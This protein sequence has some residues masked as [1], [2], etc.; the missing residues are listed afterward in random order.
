MPTEPVARNTHQWSGDEEI[1]YQ[2]LNAMAHGWLG[3]DTLAADTSALTSQTTIVKVNT[4][5]YEDNRLIK[6]SAYGTFIGATPDLVI[7]RL[8]VS[9]S[10][11]AN[12]HYTYV[13]VNLLSS[14]FSI[15]GR[16]VPGVAG[17]ASAYATIERAGSGSVI[18]QQGC[19]LIVE[20]CGDTIGDF[21]V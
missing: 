2:L 17:S 10:E 5:D 12:A 1:D 16:I 21:S 6:V 8:W 14:P 15:M 9:G 4:F 19:F 3:E 20:D 18:A 7:V 11:I 13:P